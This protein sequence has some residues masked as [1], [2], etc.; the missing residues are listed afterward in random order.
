MFSSLMPCVLK[1]SATNQKPGTWKLVRGTLKVGQRVDLCQGSKGANISPI[2]K[3]SV[4]GS[5]Y[6]VTTLSGTVYTVEV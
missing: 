5:Y 6:V 1:T 4:M 2:Q 3:I